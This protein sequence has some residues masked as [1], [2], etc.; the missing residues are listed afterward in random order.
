MKHVEECL[1]IY[2]NCLLFCILDKEID[3]DLDQSESERIYDGG[4]H[5]HEL[6]DEVI[7]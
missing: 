2:A 7:G 5:S 1:G 6:L 3:I 4:S